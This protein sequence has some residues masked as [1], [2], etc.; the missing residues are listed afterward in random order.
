MP[1]DLRVVVPNRRGIA[2]AVF[3]AIAAKGINVE[4]MCGD[5]RRGETW[6]YIHVLVEDG[7]AARAS[8]EDAGFEVVGD[9]EVE[10]LDLE[11]RLGAIADALRP[12]AEAARNITVLY[13]ASNSRLVVGTEDMLKPRPGV[14]MADV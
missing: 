6:G 13:M 1:T 10:L 5:I 7:E 9:Q 4:G 12:F 3:D 2:V 14:R 11:D 8:V